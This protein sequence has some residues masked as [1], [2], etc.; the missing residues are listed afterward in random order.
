VPIGRTVLLFLI[1]GILF[2][3]LARMC[4]EAGSAN[5]GSASGKA[6]TARKIEDALVDVRPPRPHGDVVGWRDFYFLHGGRRW[7]AVK[8][9]GYVLFVGFGLGRSSE[10]TILLRSLAIV[11]LVSLGL[12]VFEGLFAVSRAYR[13]ERRDR[14]LSSL[15][16]IPYVGENLVP[17][18][19]RAIWQSLLPGMIVIGVC[20]ILLMLFALIYLEVLFAVLFLAFY[21]IGAIYFAVWLVA[22]FSLRIKRGGLPVALV[23]TGFASMSIGVVGAFIF[24]PLSF[25]AGLI[26]AIPFLVAGAALR[27]SFISRLG[28]AASEE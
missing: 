9:V 12:T 20:L 3:V 7:Q 17:I 27:R 14:T 22:W 11:F 1:A 26:S 16:T 5:E 19:Q 6:G 2:F 25:L 13:I 8:I 4:F 28:A 15:W 18:K 24:W 10:M 23:I 21:L